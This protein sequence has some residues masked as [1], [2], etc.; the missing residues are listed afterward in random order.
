MRSAEKALER[1]RKYIRTVRK[2]RLASDPAYRESMNAYMREYK[3]A[4]RANGCKP[5]GVFKPKPKLSPAELAARARVRSEKYNS[6]EEVRQRNREHTRKS[7]ARQ[8]AEDP[9]GYAERHRERRRRF[10]SDGRAKMY[11]I[12]AESGPIKIGFTTKRMLGRLQELQCGNHERLS[13]LKVTGATREQEVAV[14]DRFVKDRIRPRGEW[15]RCTPELLAFI[16]SLPEL[17][18]LPDEATRPRS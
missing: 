15:F 12:Q 17:P 16:A 6:R 1:G 18:A 8:K 13:I 11:F 4:W 2:K 9:E 5:L 10:T 14:H 3:R 7:V